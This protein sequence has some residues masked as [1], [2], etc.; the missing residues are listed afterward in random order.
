MIDLN[1]KSLIAIQ[2]FDEYY[3]VGHQKEGF[4][5][6]KTEKGLV[7][8]DSMD[9]PDADEKYLIPGLA[10]LGLNKEKI[11]MLCLTHGHFDHYL[12]ADHVRRRTGCEVA[13]SAEDALY[14]VYSL[15]NRDKDP[16][17][18]RITKL[19]K[20]GDILQ[21]GATE[22]YV[23]GAPGHTPGCLNYVF[24]VHHHGKEHKAILFGGFGVFGP[25]QYYG[26]YP[27]TND[28]AVEQAGIFASTCVKSWEYC[29]K[30]GVDIYL[31]PHPHLC[32]MMELAAQ[33]SA[34][35]QAENA[36]VIGTEGVRQWIVDRFDDCMKSILK[37]TDIREEYKGES[38]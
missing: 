31:N 8:F 18:P 19:V 25:G 34:D 11:V 6:L 10:K 26:T 2:L 24:S 28:H 20:D 13:L 23:M 38:N 32:R 4:H 33:N 35:Q 29:K 14:M 17:I 7:L 15:D 21:F 9:I 12:G 16:L 37:F 30:N 3:F 5:I 1:D 36:L 27:E 22:V